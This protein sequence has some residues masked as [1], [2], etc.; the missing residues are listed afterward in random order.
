MAG[1]DEEHTAHS[2]PVQRKY[3]DG[4]LSERCAAIS[5]RNRK[6]FARLPL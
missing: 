6:N 4:H 5:S 1:A 2:L 3:R